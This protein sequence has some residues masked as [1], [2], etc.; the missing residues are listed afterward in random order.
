MLNSIQIQIKKFIRKIILHL[1]IHTIQ[2]KKIQI[3]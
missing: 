3:Q 2:F 1:N